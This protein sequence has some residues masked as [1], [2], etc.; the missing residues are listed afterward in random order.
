MTDE[1][2]ESDNKEGELPTMRNLV[3]EVA[4]LNYKVGIGDGARNDTDNGIGPIVLCDLLGQL[5]EEVHIEK[6][7]PTPPWQKSENEQAG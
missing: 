4:L 7:T 6:K 1:I 3:L 2:V 5:K